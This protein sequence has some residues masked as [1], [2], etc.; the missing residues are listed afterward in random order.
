MFLHTSTSAVTHGNASARRSSKSRGDTSF[1]AHRGLGIS[2][3]ICSLWGWLYARRFIAVYDNASILYK[4]LSA[5]AAFLMSPHAYIPAVHV[6]HGPR[7][8][9]KPTAFGTPPGKRSPLHVYI[10]THNCTIQSEENAHASNTTI[11]IELYSNR[12]K[13]SV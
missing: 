1:R 10:H 4:R 6:S 12:A 2:R 3:A 13:A 11:I 8:T 5:C 9:A 7:P